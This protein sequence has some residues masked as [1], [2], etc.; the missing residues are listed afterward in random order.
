MNNQ[1]Q[2]ITTWISKQADSW[3][4][5]REKLGFPETKTILSLYPAIHQPYLSARMEGAPLIVFQLDREMVGPLLV[6]LMGR[7]MPLGMI[8]E[9]LPWPEV[10]L[11]AESLKTAILS[12]RSRYLYGYLPGLSDPFKLRLGGETSWAKMLD[13]L[14]TFFNGLIAELDL[15]T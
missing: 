15:F 9:D 12:S 2:I 8:E 14:I 1:D 6:S 10:S 13:K 11:T 7:E 4:V 3:V 5:L